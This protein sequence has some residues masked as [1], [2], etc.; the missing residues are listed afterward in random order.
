MSKEETKISEDRGRM[1]KIDQ[2]ELGPMVLECLAQGMNSYSIAAKITAEV[3][4]ISQ[5]TVSR[6]IGANRRASQNK[7]K[8]LFDEHIERE[9]PKDL[10]ALEEMESICLDWARESLEVRTE[11]LMAWERVV[12]SLDDMAVAL[13]SAA[14][15]GEAKERR[16]KAKAIVARILAWVLAD[17]SDQKRRLDAMAMG[18]KIICGKLQH[19]G[20]LDGNEE[21]GVTIKPYDGSQATGG[22]NSGTG[23]SSRLFTVKSP[24]EKP[25]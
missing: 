11:R 3:T 25:L 13:M 5:P 7:A 15:E 9:I 6:W 1:T 10:D 24:Q 2:L 4:P 17:N 23:N 19:A 18:V 21:W 8:R 16:I 20:V 22:T 14:S 12:E